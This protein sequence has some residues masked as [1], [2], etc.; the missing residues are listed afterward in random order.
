MTLIFPD[1]LSSK[2]MII[3]FI[4]SCIKFLFKPATFVS[5]M[6]ANGWDFVAMF[7]LDRNARIQQRVGRLGRFVRVPHREAGPAVLK[8]SSLMQSRM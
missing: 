7:C 2:Q 3:I 5:L 6:G 1:F 8:G 4:I